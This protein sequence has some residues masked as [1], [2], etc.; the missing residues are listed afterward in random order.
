MRFFGVFLTWWGPFVVGALDSSLVFFMPF[1]VDALVIY[2]AARDETLFWIYPLLA[3]AGSLAGAAM[4]TTPETQVATRFD[5]VPQQFRRG[6]GALMVRVGLG[7]QFMLCLLNDST[8]RALAGPGAP[9]ANAGGP[10]G[11]LN[12]AQVLRDVALHKHGWV[13]FAGRR[14]RHAPVFL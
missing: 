8:V 5:A 3:T 7:Q 6:S 2:L 11:A 10:L 4:M 13:V 14:R 1:G 12:Y 9:L